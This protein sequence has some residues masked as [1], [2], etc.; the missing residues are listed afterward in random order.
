VFDHRQSLPRDP[1]TDE[2]LE[3][4]DSVVSQAGCPD[5]VVH[6]V[7]DAMS[8]PDKT[9]VVAVGCRRGLQIIDFLGSIVGAAV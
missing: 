4:P 7:T 8:Q 3:V 5:I 6:V 1:A 9:G 2:H